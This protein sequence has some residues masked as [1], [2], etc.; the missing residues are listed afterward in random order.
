MFLRLH[1]LCSMAK[2]LVLHT[3]RKVDKKGDSFFRSKRRYEMTML[4]I[5]TKDGKVHKSRKA[6]HILACED[7]DISIEDVIAC[8]F[9][10]KSREIWDN[11]KPD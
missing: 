5:K 1:P 3:V 2:T 6:I 4:L 8:G 10:S 7:L 11:R 9:L